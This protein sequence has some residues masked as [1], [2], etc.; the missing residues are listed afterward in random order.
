M[1]SSRN[2][3]KHVGKSTLRTALTF[4]LLVLASWAFASATAEDNEA[5]EAMMPAYDD[6]GSLLLPEGYERWVFVGSSLALSYTEGAPGHEMFHHTLMEPTAHQHFR[7]TGQFREGTMLALLL[8]GTGEGVLPARHGRFAAE[9]HAVEMAVKDSN[10]VD[11]TWAY[12]NFGGM[13]GVREEARPMPA[14]SCQSCHVEHA[15]YDN[16]FLQFYPL[17]VDAAPP[18]VLPRSLAGALPARNSETQGSP[19]PAD[20]SPGRLALGGLDPVHLVEGREE[21]GKPEIVVDSGGF[22][23]QFVS[24]P[25]RKT[26]AADPERYVIQNET[27]PVVPGAPI[28]PALFSVHEGRVYAFA[29]TDCVNSFEADPESFLSDD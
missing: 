16:V 21:L 18:N 1:K 8:H 29:T 23:Y 10:R 13:D 4:L 6:D 9:I 20:E 28:N 19:P 14:R 15:A 22:R 26:F 24:E 27:C 5:T 11:E 12:Y 17:L 3:R 25:S 2:S 7:E